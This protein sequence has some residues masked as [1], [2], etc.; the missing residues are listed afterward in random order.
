MK[1]NTQRLDV[2]IAD[3]CLTMNELSKQSRVNI[4]TLTKVR[5]GTQE[6]TPKTV[7]KIAKALNISVEEIIEI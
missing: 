4:V 5:K 1:I 6:P 7:G 2:A 3:A